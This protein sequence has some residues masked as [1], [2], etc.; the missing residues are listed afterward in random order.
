MERYWDTLFWGNTLR[1]WTITLAIVTGGFLIL[2]IIR[3]I[4]LKRLQAWSSRTATGFDDFLI[5]LFKRSVMPLLYLGVFN[6]GIGYLNL[7]TRATQIIQTASLVVVVF[8]VIRMVS[9]LLGYAF[10]RF[11][12]NAS[13]DPAQAKQARGILLII[14]VVLWVIGFIFLIDN[15]GYDITTI[16]TG[17]GIGGIAIALAAQTILGDLFSYLVIF[18]DKPFET[19]DFVITGSHSGIVEYIGIKTTRLRTLSGEQLIVSNTDLTNSRVQNFKRMERRRVVFPVRVTYNTGAAQLRR[20]PGMVK[21]IVT[22]IPETQFDR[23]HLAVLA[24]SCIQF[25][26]VYYVLSAD[27]VKFMNIQEAVCLGIYEAFEREGI[28]FAF[29][30]QKLLWENIAASQPVHPS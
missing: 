18:F 15:L 11:A 29:P 17:L 4:V 10:Q 14:K 2:R 7:P 27:Y 21:D 23:T 26:I 5:R 12:G 3:L 19:G 25:E 20:I 16:V 28:E 22:A 24:E 30:T 9:D 13:H 8:F 6:A 1:D